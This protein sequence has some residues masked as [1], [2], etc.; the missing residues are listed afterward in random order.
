MRQAT[1]YFSPHLPWIERSTHSWFWH[2]NCLLQEK[3]YLFLW[4]K[5]T[6]KMGLSVIYLAKHHSTQ[7]F[8]I[9]KNS[10]SFRPGNPFRRTPGVPHARQAKLIF[11]LEILIFPNPGLQP[12]GKRPGLKPRVRDFLFSLTPMR[13][14]GICNEEFRKFNLSSH[15]PSNMRLPHGQ[16]ENCCHLLFI[17]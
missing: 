8:S 16:I 15:V 9:G 12:G 3:E 6:I 4:K 10:F 7:Q 13:S 11:M 1:W 14:T 17:L 5:R 2:S